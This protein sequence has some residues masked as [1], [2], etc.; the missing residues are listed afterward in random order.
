[1]RSKQWG[2]ERE[3][4]SSVNE[5][6]ERQLGGDWDKKWRKWDKGQKRG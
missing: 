5:T 6:K 2:E 4:S 1:M 3:N